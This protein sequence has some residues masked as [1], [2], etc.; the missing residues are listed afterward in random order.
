[1]GSGGTVESSAEEPLFRSTVTAP[2][3][4]EGMAKSASKSGGSKNSSS[5]KS[6]SSKSSSSKSGSSKKK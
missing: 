5:S 1:L 3:G 4:E 6:S 2:E